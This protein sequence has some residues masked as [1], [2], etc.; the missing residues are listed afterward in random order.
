V[1]VSVVIESW[2]IDDDAAGLEAL[3]GRLAPQVAA[4]GAEVV[5]THAGTL[6]RAALE[7]VLG[8]SIIWVELPRSAGYYEHKNRGF[9]ASTG[10]V[11]AF[12]DGDCEPSA[13]WLA[14]ITA[15]L[16]RGAEVVAGAT[17]YAGALA[18]L[19]NELDF[20]Y[21][22]ELNRHFAATSRA[23]APM[24]RNFFANNV[25]FAR[26]AFAA[27]H[28]PTITPM[29][30]G[31]CQVLAM[32]LGDSGI[33]IVYAPNARVTHAWPDSAR[34]WLEVRLL[35]GADART[36]LP[37]VLER[38]APRVRA[39]VTRLG[40]LP[41]L[42]VLGV[43]AVLGAVSALRRGPRARGLALVAGCTAIDAVGAIAAPIVYRYL[44]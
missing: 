35:R 12:I 2:N 23:T 17:S 40:P 7:A 32:Q 16:G 18:P 43:R 42:A 11:V 9:D 30:H 33:P 36:L 28:Y 20:P 3:L 29:F 39:L 31:Q 21:F 27:R 41:A 26:A 5:L 4:A 38:H 13:E 22:D 19:A 14:S 25:A 37:H 8:R 34:E 1:T 10:D 6:P 24:V 44:A 15:P